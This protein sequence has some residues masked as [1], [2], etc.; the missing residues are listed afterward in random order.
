MGKAW[1]TLQNAI[2]FGK[3]G[4]TALKSTITFLN[5]FT[6]GGCYQTQD[7]G[8]GRERCIHERRAILALSV[9]GKPTE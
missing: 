6:K 9:A 1:G 3:S 4:S 8:M 7:N 2:M 5:Q